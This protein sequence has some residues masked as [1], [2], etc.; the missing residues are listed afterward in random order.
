MAPS[1]EVKCLT[2]GKTIKVGHQHAGKKGKCPVCSKVITIPDPSEK[3]ESLAFNEDVS[4]EDRQRAAAAISGNPDM[5]VG[6]TSQQ[7]K[8]KGFF[9]KLFGKKK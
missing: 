1:I 3:K 5:A 2:C 4:D 9:G 6:A 8:K 7:K